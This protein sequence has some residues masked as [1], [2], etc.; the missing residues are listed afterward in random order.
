MNLTADQFF[1]KFSDIVEDL[2]IESVELIREAI[3]SGAEVKL[4]KH[5]SSVRKDFH[6]IFVPKVY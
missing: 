1:S 3:N 6:F 5:Q 4:K 2:S